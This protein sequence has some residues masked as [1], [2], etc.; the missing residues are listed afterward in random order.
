MLQQPFRSILQSEYFDLHP[1]GVWSAHWRSAADRI[2]P[3]TATGTAAQ[4]VWHGKTLKQFLQEESSPYAP[5]QALDREIVKP[6]LAS[7]QRRLRERCPFDDWPS[8]G[9]HLDLIVLKGH[10]S[11]QAEGRL[12]AEKLLECTGKW[13]KYMSPWLLRF[14]KTKAMHHIYGTM[15]DRRDALV[16]SVPQDVARQFQAPLAKHS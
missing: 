9:Q 14:T 4:E 1:D 11:M 3:G 8:A 13:L 16:T 7:L 6:A 12:C 10:A 15:Y 5:A 2:Q